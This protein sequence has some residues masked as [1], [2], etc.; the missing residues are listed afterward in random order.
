MQ[1][2][3][4]LVKRAQRP[5]KRIDGADEDEIKALLGEEAE[6][7]LTAVPRRRSSAS[8]PAPRPP[9]YEQVILHPIHLAVP[10]IGL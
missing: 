4:K 6:A 9:H 3:G 7:E 10:S 5:V 2:D 8:I 1:E